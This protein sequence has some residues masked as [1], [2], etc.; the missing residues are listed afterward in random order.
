VKLANN[1]PANAEDGVK[2]H[3]RRLLD[4][5]QRPVKSALSRP[6]ITIAPQNDLAGTIGASTRGR[7]TPLPMVNTL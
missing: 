4:G 5:R 3:H 2:R 1:L 7:V 6:A